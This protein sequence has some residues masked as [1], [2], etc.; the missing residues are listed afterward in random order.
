MELDELEDNVK[1]VFDKEE[2]DILVQGCTF[3]YKETEEREISYPNAETLMQ[4]FC[5]I[6]NDQKLQRHFIEILKENVAASVETVWASGRGDCHYITSSAVAFYTLVQLGY[7]DE[8]VAALRD[9]L[10]KS[11]YIYLMLIHILGK[12][13]LDSSQLRGI[14]DVIRQDNQNDEIVL[15][16]KTRIA[17]TRMESL[18]ARIDIVNIE[19]NQD[20]KKLTEKIT[21]LGFNENFNKLLHSIDSFILAETSE[22]VTAGIIS[23]LRSFMADLLKEIAQEIAKQEGSTISHIQGRGEMG[24]IRAFLKNK[25]EL[26]DADENFVDSFVDIL[27]SGRWSCFHV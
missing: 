8:A 3:F 26:T 13:N 20:K 4:I 1:I 9:R 25:L 19:I 2:N 12:V 21:Y 27:Q 6:G 5:T 22:V 14:A 16:V 7:A 10:E 18:K 11:H 17:Q 15:G 24:D 23:T